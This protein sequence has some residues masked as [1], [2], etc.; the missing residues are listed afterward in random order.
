MSRDLAGTGVSANVLIPGG[1]ANTPMVSDDLMWPDRSKLVQPP[2]MI[3]PV[4]WLGTP[5]G[6]TGM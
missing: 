2:Q 5:I 4:V 6:P 1:P 3:A